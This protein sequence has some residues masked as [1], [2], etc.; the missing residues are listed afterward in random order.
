MALAAF[1]QEG[2]IDQGETVAM[3]WAE[4]GD[5]EQALTWQRRVLGQLGGGESL[6]RVSQIR[7]RLALY[8]NQQPCRAPWKDN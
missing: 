4:Q 7:Q 8:E 1:E 3:A 6:A 2:T 5:F